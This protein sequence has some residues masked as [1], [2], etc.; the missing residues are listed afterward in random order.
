MRDGSLQGIQAVVERQQ[1]VPAEGDNDSLILEGK[2]RR[3]RL[4]RPGRAISDRAALLPFCDRLGVDPAAFGEPPQALL[5]TLY[6]STDR[7][8]RGGAA[9]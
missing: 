1:C 9:V 7:L 4:P 2:D 6:R 8:C 3:A 5:T